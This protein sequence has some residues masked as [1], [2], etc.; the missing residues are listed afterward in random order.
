M[1]GSS[2]SMVTKPFQENTVNDVSHCIVI[3]KLF[4]SFSF[5]V[6]II[7]PRRNFRTFFDEML[8]KND[9]R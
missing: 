3:L 2:K 9:N 8:V 6:I 4:Y 7:I 1:D 5:S